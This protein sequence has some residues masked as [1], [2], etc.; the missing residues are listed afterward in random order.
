MLSDIFTSLVAML[1]SILVLLPLT[2]YIYK[3]FERK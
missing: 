3:K 2:Y 1:V